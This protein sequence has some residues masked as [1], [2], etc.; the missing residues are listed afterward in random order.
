MK[1]ALQ[2]F[3]FLLRADARGERAVLA[4]ITDVIGASPRAPGTHMA[5]AESGEYVGTFS[6][7]CTEAA[8]VGE[9]RRVLDAGIAET[10]RLGAGSPYIDIRLPCGGGLDILFTPSLPADRLR[11]VRDRL[12][13]RRPAAL[14]LGIDGSV[15]VETAANGVASGWSGGRFIARH[16]P[17]LRVLV[18]GQGAETETLAKLASSFGAEAIVFSPDAVSVDAVRG[19]GIE[20]HHLATG[21]PPQNVSIDSFTAIVFLFH[22][23]EWEVGLLKWALD[24]DAFY[25]GAMGSRATHARRIAQL[26]SEGLSETDCARIVGPIGLIPA[27]RDPDTLALSV[28]SEIVSRQ[29]RHF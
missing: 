25:I 10:V 11:E 15:V 20:A 5:V 23:H 21:A 28:L 14:S 4:T 19:H 12:A 24:S 22:D 8:V 29:G 18:F 17:D 26:A 6:G 13:S 16:D 1:R 2:I 27:T 3:E 7:G 9:A